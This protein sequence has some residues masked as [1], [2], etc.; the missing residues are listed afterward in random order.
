MSN[1]VYDKPFNRRMYSGFKRRNRKTIKNNLSS[2][3]IE[4]LVKVINE[5][6]AGAK[7]IMQL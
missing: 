2:T 4:K 7:E 5:G 3:L 6:D 1:K